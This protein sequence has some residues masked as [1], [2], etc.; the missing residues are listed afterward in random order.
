MWRL[1]ER[2]PLML[3]IEVADLRKRYPVRPTPDDALKGADPEARAQEVFGLL[4]PNGAGK[5]TL[6]KI[7]CRLLTAT[8][9]SVK[10]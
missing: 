7:I 10:V 9:G 1:R 2:S 3:A 6:L 5:T 8:S 4:G